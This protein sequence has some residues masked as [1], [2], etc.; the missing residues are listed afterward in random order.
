MNFEWDE[1]KNLKN[2]KNHGV[3]FVQAALV[4]CDPLR[5]ERYDDTHSENEDRV[6]AI[7]SAGGRILVVSFTEIS[8]D[9]VRIISARKAKKGEKE[10]YYGNR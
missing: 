3:S 4:F 5:K 10:F 9:T 2:I 8:S 7:G 6:I 1:T